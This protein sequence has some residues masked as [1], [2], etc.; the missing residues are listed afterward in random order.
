MSLAALDWTLRAVAEGRAAQEIPTLRQLGEP[1]AAV[2]E[3]AR[4]LLVRIE[5]VADAR[6]EAELEVTRAPVG[7][8]SL[9]GFELPSRAVTLRGA[10]GAERLCSALR[11]GPVPVLARVRDDR[12][13]LDAR[14]LLPGDEAVVVSAL[15]RA[16]EDV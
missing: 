10:L 4:E 16:L 13:Q 2:E 7:G 5:E 14:T 6:I 8:G 9:P 12:V 1:L 3:R 11:R 15:R